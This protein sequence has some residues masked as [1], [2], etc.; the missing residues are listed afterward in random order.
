MYQNVS[1]WQTQVTR[2]YVR[3]HVSK[4]SSEPLDIITVMAIKTSYNWLFLWD[5]IHS[6]NGVTC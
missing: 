3:L 2:K 4:L 1:Q 6:I 5:E